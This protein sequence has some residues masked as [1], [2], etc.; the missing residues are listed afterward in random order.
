MSLVTSSFL[1]DALKRPVTIY[2]AF[3]TDK[4]VC[5]DEY[6]PEKK[7]LKTLYFLEGL[8]G[9]A[10]GPISYTHLQSIAEDNNLCVIAVA[11]DNKWYADSDTTGDYYGKLIEEDLIRYT[12]DTFNI[13]H[14][15]EDTFIG[16]FSMGG[17][18]ALTCGLRRPD[19]F[20]KILVLDAALNKNVIINA[21]EVASTDMYNRR[22][23]EAMFDLKDVADF[24]N[25]DDDYEYLAKKV[26]EEQKDLMPDIFFSC[27]GADGLLPLNEAY[28]DYLIDLGYNVEFKVQPGLGHS[29]AALEDGLLDAVKWLPLDGFRGNIIQSTREQNFGY[30]EYVNWKIYYNLV[31]DK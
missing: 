29:F 2:A 13:S 20:S 27:G 15:R 3:P 23:Y 24:A 12:R 10:H 4:M 31:A 6:I 16:G 1:T 28:R 18:G 17:F 9:A 25:S 8:T 19:L 11:G 30:K 14:K 5:P 26:A 22:Q 21:Q 7:P